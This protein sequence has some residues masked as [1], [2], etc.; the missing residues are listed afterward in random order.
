MSKPKVKHDDR[1]DFL[2][3]TK[4][5]PHNSDSQSSFN[6]S[7]M[8]I[9]QERKRSEPDLFGAPSRNLDFESAEIPSMAGTHNVDVDDV[10]IQDDLAI[11]DSDEDEQEQKSHNN[12]RSKSS[13]DNV[14]DDDLW[15]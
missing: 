15:F 12:D 6:M 5:E 4:P 13:A 8:L 3:T 11:S 14:N 10:G 7:D 1:G 9:Q 2:K